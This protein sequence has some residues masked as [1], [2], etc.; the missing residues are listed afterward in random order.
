MQ[1][2]HHFSRAPHINKLAT[3][4]IY[5]GKKFYISL[6]NYPQPSFCFC[7]F[8]FFIYRG[9]SFRLLRRIIWGL[10]SFLFLLFFTFFLFWQ[11]LRFDV[12]IFIF[13]IF[14]QMI[15]AIG[16]IWDR[17]RHHLATK[18]LLGSSLRNASRCLIIN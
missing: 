16:R 2:R 9:N 8:A 10:F 15:M 11:E 18:A 12:Y 1:L 5:Q 7:Y 13:Y 6:I 14:L 4:L 3:S 17:W